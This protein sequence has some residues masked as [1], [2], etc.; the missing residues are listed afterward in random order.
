MKVRTCEK[1]RLLKPQTFF[2]AQQQFNGSS[3]HK[4]SEPF[5]QNNKIKLKKTTLCV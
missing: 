3:K 4:L 1:V 5:W 2:T